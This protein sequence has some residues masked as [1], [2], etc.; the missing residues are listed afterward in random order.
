[1]SKFLLWS[2]LAWATGSPMG[3]LVALLVLWWA[4]DRFTVKLLPD[5]L[6]AVGRWRRRGALRRAIAANPSD[7][8]SRFEL[9]QLLLETRRPAAAIEVLRPNLEAGDDDV[10]TAFLFGALLVRT[11]GTEQAERVL[12]IAR[13]AEPGYRLGEIDLELG[14][15]R[16]SRGD[17][18]GAREA[19]T[20]LVQARP[21]TVQGR[22]LLARALDGLG[23]AGGGRLRDEA[24]REYVA[25]PRF[26]R[27]EER[28]WAWRIRPWRPAIVAAVLV[29]AGAFAARAVLGVAPS[30]TP[31]AAE[32]VEGDR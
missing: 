17:F 6:R 12:E 29:L 19:L 4:A 1:M 31:Q 14:R 16:L 32:A 11:G 7:R 10:H 13:A 8:R 23:D 25:L 5:P 15:S 20:R 2:M 22:V 9:A 3:S 27:R 26:R 28:P 21:G 30:P 18:A 24:W